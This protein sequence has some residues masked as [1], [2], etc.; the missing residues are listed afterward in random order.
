ME[1]LFN[2][3]RTLV[4]LP[5]NVKT[6]TI[7]E[8]Q[9]LLNRHEPFFRLRF[10]E[11]PKGIKASE[12]F[13]R[14]F[15][16]VVQD[17]ANSI[18]AKL[19]FAVPIWQKVFNAIL[20]TSLVG[21]RVVFDRVLQLTLD[22]LYLTIGEDHRVA[23]IEVSSATLFF[24]LESDNE[25][26]QVESELALDEKLAQVIKTL[27][28][29]LVPLYK[30][31][32]VSPKVFWG[33]ALYACDLAFSKLAHQPLANDTLD[34]DVQAASKWQQNLFNAVTPKG[35]ELN[36]VKKVIFN[37]FQKLY[38]RR[39]TCCLKYKIEGKEKCSTCNLHDSEI[40]ENI[41]R[42]NML[43]LFQ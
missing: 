32:K 37:G 6:L 43:G 38:V 8:Q 27:S 28:E 36:A 33:N 1:N 25:A 35:G 30:K 26:M 10:V 22:D 34:L 21:H 7:A 29:P 40:Q 9:A 12:W 4:A 42:M 18:E 14:E 5:E 13:E 31:Q 23:S 15:P 17:Y 2:Q 19:P 24:S 39:E 11:Q 41:M 3:F 16:A 20:L